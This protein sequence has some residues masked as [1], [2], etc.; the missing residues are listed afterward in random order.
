MLRRLEGY[1]EWKNDPSSREY[2][3]ELLRNIITQLRKA[4]ED[5]DKTAISFLLRTSTIFCVNVVTARSY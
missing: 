5:G 4:R 1:E 2:D 3:Y